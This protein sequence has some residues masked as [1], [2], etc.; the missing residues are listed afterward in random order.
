MT[1][2]IQLEQAIIAVEAQRASLGNAAADTILEGLR[3]QLAELEKSENQRQPKTAPL[4]GERRIVTILFCDVTGSTALAESMD[5]EAWT[6]IMNAIFEHLIEPVER[7]QGT[8]ARLMGDAILAIFGAPIA[9]ED[10]P[11]RAVLAG[12]AIL[13][14]IGP[15]CEK[16]QKEQNLSLN[17]R[18]GI[19]TGLAIV[20]DVGSDRA[21]EYTAMGDAVN[22]AAR[23]EQTAKPGTVQITENTCRLVAPLF[24][25]ESLG[26]IEVKG[27]AD[28]VQSY[29]VL[30]RKAIPGQ[31]RGIEGLESPLIGRQQELERLINASDCLERSEGRIIC[32]IGEAGL[33]KSRL[34][35]EMRQAILPIT[36]NNRRSS[37]N[38][39]RP[40]AWYQ[41][42]SLP[43]E[44]EHPY[45]MFQ[46]L[47]RRLVGLGAEDSPTLLK[48][49]FKA[50][51]ATQFRV[52]ELPD[53]ERNGLSQVFESLFGL[54][55]EED[56][57]PLESE[58]SLE[59]EAF[60][61]RLYTVMKHLWRYQAEQ[62]PVVLVAEDLHWS[63]PASV[64][65]L[66]HLMPLCDQ[67]PLLLIFVLRPDRESPGWKLRQ[68]AAEEYPHRYSEIALQPLSRE[69]SSLLV[70]SLLQIS[71]LP[72][73]LREHI[74]ERSEG[75][76]LFV[77]E[78]VRS[79]IDHRVV[80]RDEK[81]ER[82]QATS[83]GQN[84]DIPDN[85]Q[86]LL[87]A[88]I[89]RL[90]EDTR[91]TLQIASVAG[92][93]FYYRVLARIVELA[94]ELDGQLLTLQ[95]T[96]MIREARRVPELEYNFRHALTQEAAYSTILL[97]ERQVF[98]RQVGEA[99]EALFPKQTDK[100]AGELAGHFFQA[101]DYERALKYYIISGDRAFHLHALDESISHYSQ[102]LSLVDQTEAGIQE[103]T[104]LYTRIG[105]A[106]EL[107]D[108]YDEALSTYQRMESIARDRDDQ[109]MLLA[110]LMSRFTLR[111]IVT[112]VH[113]LLRAE[114][115]SE[116]T[117]DLARELE[118]QAAEATILWN[119]MNL[120]RYTSRMRQAID[121][122]ERS[123][124]L[125]RKLN[126]RE[127]T[128]YTL[129]DIAHC[130]EGIGQFY[131]AKEALREAAVIWTE[132]GNKP[133]LADSLSSAVWPNR[134]TGEYETALWASNEAYT[135]CQS[136]GNVRGQAYSRY[137]IGFVHWDRG[138]PSRALEAMEESLRQGEMVDFYTP[139][140]FTRIGMAAV[141]GGLG[142]PLRGLKLARL[143]LEYAESEVPIYRVY[144]LSALVE[145]HLLQGN[146]AEAAAALSL[147]QSDPLRDAYPASNIHFLLAVG[148]LAH[149]QGDYTQAIAVIETLLTKLRQFG[150]KAFMPDALYLQGRAYEELEQGQSARKCLQEARANAENIGSRRMLWP[151]LFS[152]SQLEADSV[153]AAH[154]R[155]QAQ[156]IIH[157]I[158]GNIDV[159]DLRTT[160]LNQP[161]VQEL[162]N[163]VE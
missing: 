63:D 114:A 91:R 29:R 78:M 73:R 124:T 42:E 51:S 1:D 138:Q 16:L 5:P 100:L 122:G 145:L 140:L 153:K 28:P 96:D 89:D 149:G 7:Y 102:A 12:L 36:I 162:L 47:I 52:D 147:A 38:S 13:E 90:A 106:L 141:Y 4:S 117:L 45:A 105:R 60:R 9:H 83:E 129:N 77:E 88:R 6:E 44:S 135:I 131:Q 155:Q 123:L 121:C 94:E 32:L 142:D 92:R 64:A 116:Q 152:L 157:Y 62:G 115:L 23:M 156:E 97:R 57:R 56:K 68:V 46:R 109:T 71:D 53:E 10:D 130:Y 43:Y 148:K 132:L 127:Q 40:L 30:G 79:L 163:S 55:S 128:A 58:P 146:V 118:D 151:I 125:A 11:Q 143:A 22:L 101:G 34:I 25:C 95:Q 161:L 59:G 76:P 144:S 69:R 120:Y 2:R 104:K 98:H 8:V 61:D 159:T 75:N 18:V 139:R 26:G 81:G 41:T 54:K 99:L 126:L 66:K 119:T 113:D 24:D 65:L 70:D 21:V 108:Q 86:G 49:K 134:Y 19:N 85:L 72:Q 84:I 82:W 33:G 158:S 17:V 110:A 137:D 103:L 74:L 107:S 154:I 31:L 14:N 35:H 3:Q 87:V 15:F 111:A 67:V 160:F 136:I 133:M 20:G 37:V 93:S 39:P 48:E 50:F 150:A 112:P 80:V 27:K